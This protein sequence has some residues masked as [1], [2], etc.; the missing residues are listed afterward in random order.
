MAE[1]GLAHAALGHDA[2]RDLHGLLRKGIIIAL[3]LRGV[4]ASYKSGL[5][6]GVSPLLL[7]VLQLIAAYAEEFSKVLLLRRRFISHILAHTQ[8]SSVIFHGNNFEMQNSDGGV[9]IYLI[10]RDVA[11]KAPAEG[12]IIGYAAGHGVCLLRAYDGVLILIAL[13]EVAHLDDAA[14]GNGAFS[15]SGVYLFNYFCIFNEVF[16]LRYL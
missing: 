4:R 9:N 10:A 2:P 14:K 13:V 1:D 3:Y 7:Q 8:S 11:V 5:L 12:G 16:D 6:E 15:G